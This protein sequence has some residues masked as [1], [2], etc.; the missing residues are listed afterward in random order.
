VIFLL[1]WLG[2]TLAGTTDSPTE[3]D[4]DPKARE[5]EINYL[6]D[7]IANYVSIKVRREDVSA[8]W[9][10]IRPLAKDPTATNTASVVRDHVISV[11]DSNLLTITGGKWTTYRSMAQE[12]VDRAIE[13]CLI[14]ISFV[15]FQPNI[16]LHSWEAL[17][18]Q[19]LV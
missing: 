11:S 8:A 7:T 4:A 9:S 14:Y 5:E 2:K 17:N 19:A 16:Y 18:M 15:F 12:A 1:P 13:V 10:G 3:L 6:L